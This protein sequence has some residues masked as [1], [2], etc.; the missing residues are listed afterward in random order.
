MGNT[1]SRKGGRKEGNLL[2][3]AVTC[4]WIHMGNTYSRKGGRKKAVFV[5]NRYKPTERL[6]ARFWSAN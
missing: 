5:V 6:I 3:L 4:Q 2:V 1:Y